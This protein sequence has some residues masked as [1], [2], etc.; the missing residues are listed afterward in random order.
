MYT[1]I[2]LASFLPVGKETLLKNICYKRKEI[3]SVYSRVEG[4]FCPSL[5]L[6]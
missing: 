2:G 6:M 5:Q 4:P 3:G 1:P